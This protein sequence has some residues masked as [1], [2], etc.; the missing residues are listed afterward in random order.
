MSDTIDHVGVIHEDG[1]LPDDPRPAQKLS[2]RIEKDAF[3]VWLCFAPEGVKPGDPETD[4]AMVRLEAWDGFLWLRAWRKDEMED[5]FLNE[6]L[7][8]LPEAK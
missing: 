6:R 4:V 1:R 5:P 8:K 7:Y 3:N 2:V